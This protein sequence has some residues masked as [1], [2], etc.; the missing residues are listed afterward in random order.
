MQRG[1]IMKLN[2]KDFQLEKSMSLYD[3]F[4]EKEIKMDRVVVELNGDIIPK[5]KFNTSI[6]KNDDSL[7]VISF[8]GG[9]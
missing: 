3:F 6:I 5:E 4:I 2:G 1:D 8:V 7:E 9:G